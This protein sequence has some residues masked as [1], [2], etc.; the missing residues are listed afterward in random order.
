MKATSS[1]EVAL[2]TQR[3][4]RDVACSSG[5]I[6]ERDR[7]Y[8]V[9]FNNGIRLP[10][11]FEYDNGTETLSRLEAKLGG[12]ANLVRAVEHAN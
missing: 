5:A 1:S 4:C 3:R 6:T 12:C 8:G 2:R 7:L 10:F 11:Y 9:W